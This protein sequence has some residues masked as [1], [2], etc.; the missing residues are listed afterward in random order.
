M[1]VVDFARV[2][3]RIGGGRRRG[4]GKA[5][6]NEEVGFADAVVS[7]SLAVSM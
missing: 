1:D 5:R 6:C 2:G 3:K 4:V 7:A